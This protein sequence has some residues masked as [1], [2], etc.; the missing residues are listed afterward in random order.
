MTVAVVESQSASQAHHEDAQ[1]EQQLS[2]LPPAT[3][4]AAEQAPQVE[5]PAVDPPPS[6]RQHPKAALWGAHQ[7]AASCPLARGPWEEEAELVSREDGHPAA[8]SQPY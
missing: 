3:K 8:G 5:A 6:V 2:R 1:V 7:A 4:C